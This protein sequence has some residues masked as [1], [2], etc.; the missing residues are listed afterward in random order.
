MGIVQ[1]LFG[2]VMMVSSRPPGLEGSSLA[3]HT[4]AIVVVAGL[5]MVSIGAFSCFAATALRRNR[6]FARSLVA[7][8][9]IASLPLFPFGTAAG[10]VG[11]YWC[12]SKKMRAL[13]PLVENFEYQP[14][15]GDGTQA[16]IQKAVSVLEIGI[17]FASFA[18]M[19]WWGRTHRLPSNGG[20]NGLLLLFLCS[21]IAAF[22]HELGHAA[23]G[24]K[25]GMTLAGFA[26]G[27]FVAQKRSG[28]WKFRFSL[29][30]MLAVGG[31]VVSV[32]LH[33]NNL[34]RRM[35]FEIAA[36]PAA[37]LVT[38][39][40]AFLILLAMPGSAFERWWMVPAMVSALS[41]GAA[42]VNLIPFGVAAGFTDG[43]L[44]V[45]LLRGGPFGDL[46]EAM[47][48]VGCTMAT[49]IRPRDLDAAGLTHGM[50]AGIGTPQEGTLHMIQLICAVDRGELT[51][52]REHL[53]SSLLR[54]PT[55][56]KATDPGCAAEMAFYM[57]YLDGDASRAGQW[58]RD[59]EQLAAK[60]KFKLSDF[61]YWRAVTAVREAEEL[62][63]EA[64]EA[65]RQATDFA[66]QRPRTGMYD[67]EWELLDK[68]RER[69]WLR[70]P[71]A[72]VIQAALLEVDQGE[73]AV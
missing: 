24:W 14:K 73:L 5:M 62:R 72:P 25:V 16:W 54:I 57:A 41:A 34:R 11:L 29:L 20:L 66:K 36:G 44:L 42:V 45:Q 65:W 15:P 22:C 32:P 18:A 28:R 49:S 12:C 60:R 71:D 56:D 19:G 27:P 7:I 10:A 9:S 53:E 33:L 31:S 70:L 69:T 48:M 47:K 26:V 23:A 39:L 17:L 3:R 64:D 61:D 37:S 35:A 40:I 67:S 52:A 51:I 21:W 6:R 38:A 58:L 50:R 4:S 30:A 59:T 68:L 63:P 2:V 43:A 46:R 55:P 13:E 8:N 1:I